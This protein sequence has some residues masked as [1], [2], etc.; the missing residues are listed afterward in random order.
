MISVQGHAPVPLSA[1][2]RRPRILIV[3]GPD[4]NLRIDLMSVLA[5]EFDVQAAGSE[6]KLDSDFRRAGFAFHFFPLHRGARPWQ[7]L[8][9]MLV[10]V[11]VF[12]RTRPDV[13]HTFSTKPGV[14][15]RI[16]ARLAGVPII[17][18]TLPGLGSLY[19]GHG[20][21]TRGLRWI[22]ES[23]QRIASRA[24]VLTIFQNQQDAD[25]FTA[26]GIVPAAGV[27]VIPGSGVR[28]DHFR[29]DRVSAEARARIRAEIEATDEN[30]VVTMVSRLI[31][32]KGVL[33]F[34]A[35]AELVR[36]RCP[37]ARFVLV[38]PDDQDSGDGIPPAEIARL[39]E[40]VAWLGPRDD[41]RAIL[42][43]TDV[44]VLPS[45]YREGIPRVLLEAAAMELPIVATRVRGCIEV[46]ED[47][48]N[49]LLVPPRDIGALAESIIEL[50][51]CPAARLAFGRT[52]RERAVTRFDVSVIA[53]E[54]ATLYARFLRDRPRS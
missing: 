33:E 25:E 8:R 26:R 16:A 30:V 23:L 39:R 6:R 45:Y 29:P 24:S 19:V 4:A 52:S 10:L 9:S 47:R 15:G 49:G 3:E 40:H 2:G 48:V 13:V 32:S 41:V 12:R 37:G 35:A 5:G 28:T 42:A 54:T 11:S 43:S 34:A 36:K 14:W 38:G 44:F 1:S 21:R 20:R 46:V 17:I 7:D 51:E 27:A 22:Y 53:R 50:V 18:G 31:R